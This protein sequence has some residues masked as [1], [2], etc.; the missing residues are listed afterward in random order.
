MATAGS[1]A[2]SPNFSAA[3]LISITAA[4]V[5][6]GR[7]A[8]PALLELLTLRLLPHERFRR[9]VV[10][11]PLGLGVPRWEDDPS[12]DLRAHVQRADLGGRSLEGATAARS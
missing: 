12:F 2:E 1:G 8:L 10:E 7:L 9:R 4:L 11:P 6:A 3:A 5:M